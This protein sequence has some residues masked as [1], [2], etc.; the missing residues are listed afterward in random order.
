MTEGK[1][2]FHFEVKT[3]K[4]LPKSYPIKTTNRGYLHCPSPR[5]QV[6]K[7]TEIAVME[8]LFFL[9]LGNS[10]TQKD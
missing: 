3:I 10:S 9:L 5:G 2:F 8:P 6:N 7:R 4:T 1:I